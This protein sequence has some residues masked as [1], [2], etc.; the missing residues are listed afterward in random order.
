[1]QAQAI[2]R[3]LGA[4]R[5]VLALLVV[6]QHGVHLLEPTA[7]GFLFTMGFG[8]VAVAVFFVISGFVV[9]EANST[10]Y[11]GRP[12]K[13]LLNRVL[14]LVPPYLAALVIEILSAA[15][16]YHADKFTPWDFELIGSP[17][18]PSLL[19]GGVLALLPGFHTRYVSGQ[20]FEFFAFVWTLRIEFT[21]YLAA[22]VVYWVGQ[23]RGI[24]PR[25]VTRHAGTLGLAGGYA[26]FVL[27]LMRRSGPE[28]FGLAPFFLLGV[29]FFLVWQKRTAWYWLHLVFALGCV[30]MAF[31]LWKQTNAPAMAYQ[32]PVL[33][34]LLAVFAVLAF[35]SGV[36]KRWKKPDVFLGNLS[37][38]LYLNHYAVLLTASNLFPERAGFGLYGVAIVVSILLAL[39]M[40]YLV[41]TPLKSIRDAVRGARL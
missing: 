41:E 15:Y 8:I 2:Y 24:V 31:P 14:R 18:Q 17:L 4:L 6:I 33:L 5:F 13:F 10:F 16:L 7:Q 19:L 3:P 29:A 34:V 40:H 11:E 27:F 21:F 37:Y 23:T 12:G 9:A 36:G 20:D 22:A 35:A 39:G 25:W 38:P 32:M 26:L 30:V 28:Q 1:M